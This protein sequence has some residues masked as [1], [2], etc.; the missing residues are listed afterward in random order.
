MLVVSGEGELMALLTARLFPRQLDNGYRGHI[1]ALWLLVPL[2]LMKFL[3]GANVAGFFG[4]GNSRRILEGVDRV[5]LGAFPAEAA[6][7]LV[8]LFAAWGVGV[9]ILGLL[10]IVALLRYRAM[11]PLVY[12][13]LL[14]EQVGRKALAMIHLDRPFVSLTASPANLINWGL[15]LALVIGFPLS[16]LDRRPRT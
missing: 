12:L 6:S 10:G 11:I 14:I 7:H 5:P 3:Q 15:L 16:L 2:V 9:F 13:L 4:T 1:L 8:F